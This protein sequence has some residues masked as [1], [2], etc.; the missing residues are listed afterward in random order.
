LWPTWRDLIVA[1]ATN[2]VATVVVNAVSW[3]WLR[4]RLGLI[5]A[6]ILAL[7]IETVRIVVDVFQY[8][9]DPSSNMGL[10]L[11]ALIVL[12]AINPS[13]GSGVQKHSILVIV[14]PEST[15]DC[16]ADGGAALA[17]GMMFLR[18]PY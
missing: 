18:P 13:S 15:D 7:L 17:E 12:I 5:V 11:Y 4:L 9:A 8:L 3:L 6:T 10:L 2:V 1:V 16:D 14:N